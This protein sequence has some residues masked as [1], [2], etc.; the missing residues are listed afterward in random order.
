MKVTKTRLFRFEKLVEIRSPLSIYRQRPSSGT[1]GQRFTQWCHQY[2]LRM[3]L[4]EILVQQIISLSLP[5]FT[6]LIFC[7]HYE[8]VC[9]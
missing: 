4:S 8:L 7:I 1:S 9:Q 5:Y 2:G 3:N 6:F